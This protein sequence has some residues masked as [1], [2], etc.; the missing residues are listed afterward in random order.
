MD[1]QVRSV[2]EE[3]VTSI[4]MA[5]QSSVTLASASSP[6]GFTTQETNADGERNGLW[7][8]W[9]MTIGGSL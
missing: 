4:F 6:Q 8:N 3:H 2:S 5:A 7:E 9:N 1:L